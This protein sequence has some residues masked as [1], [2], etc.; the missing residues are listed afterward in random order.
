M[1]GDG[2]KGG[3]HFFAGCLAA[4]MGLYNLGEA[5]SA[6]RQRRH[7]VNALVY[8]GATVYE[9]VNTREHWRRDA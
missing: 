3:V 1:T 9:A 5:C 2:Y 6:R 8:L 4:A 7:M